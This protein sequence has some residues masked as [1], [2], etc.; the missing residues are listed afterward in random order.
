MDNGYYQMHEYKA[1]AW[2]Q[3]LN[4][5][6]SHIV[7]LTS[8]NTPIHRWSLPGVPDGFQVFI[9]RDDLTGVELSGS[10]VRILQFL[11]AEALRH[12]ARHVVTGGC[13]QSNHCRAV[14]LTCRQLG[15]T[16][17]IVV[18]RVSKKEE[19]GAKGNALLYRLAGSHLYM[20]P[21]CSYEAFSQ[22][23]RSL[24]GYISDKYREPC[25]CIPL[26]GASSPG[27]FAFI[28]LFQELIEQGLFDNFDDIVVSIATGCTAAGIAVGNYLTGSKLRIHAVSIA[29]SKE[30]LTKRIDRMLSDIELTLGAN[31]IMDIIDDYIG[32]GYGTATEGLL[33]TITN[34]SANTGILLDPY[35]T[36]K[37]TQGLLE[38][39]KKTPSR[40]QGKR[41]LFI[42][43]GGIFGLFNGE[44]DRVMNLP[45]NHAYY[46]NEWPEKDIPLVQ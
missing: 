30:E 16:P 41:I 29:L 42:H 5:I 4:H 17:H 12:N 6:P 15:L 23:L 22:R 9:K 1:P 18:A 11:F 20:S 34:V 37:G 33:E 25:Y 45:G 35:Y 44:M 27:M 24:A 32:E 2:A 31:D 8:L 43:T 28:T 14:A 36:G 39:L 10:K 46:I 21:T 13:L 7:K 38:E 26:G 3:H 19:L 40:F